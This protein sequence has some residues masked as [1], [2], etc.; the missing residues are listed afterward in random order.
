MQP[1]VFINT[2][3]CKLSRVTTGLTLTEACEQLDN[4]KTYRISTTPRGIKCIG[5]RTAF[6]IKVFGMFIQGTNPDLEIV[7]Q[8]LNKRFEA[9]NFILEIDPGARQHILAQPWGSRLITILDKYI[10]AVE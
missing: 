10:S 8:V 1:T 3:N 7:E 5:I 4:V 2:E 9:H 6:D